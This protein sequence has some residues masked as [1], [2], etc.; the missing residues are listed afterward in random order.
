M[1]IN[2]GDLKGLI[3]PAFGGILAVLP[4]YFLFVRQIMSNKDAAIETLREQNKS[5]ERE[6]LPLVIQEKLTLTQDIAARA[7]EKMETD[8]SMD[9]MSATIRKITEDV[10][11]HTETREHLV[12]LIS[13]LASKVRDITESVTKR[14]ILDESVGLL[15]GA[16]M[17]QESFVEWRLLLQTLPSSPSTTRFDTYLDRQYKTTKVI[18][19]RVRAGGDLVKIEELTIDPQLKEKISEIAKA[20]RGQGI[21]VS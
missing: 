15:L 3:A 10:K 4:I 17:F 8:K 16:K 2:L 13:T 11:A 7:R 5:L 14:R 20:S 6:R 9:E 19:D 21:V 18:L 1:T 12:G